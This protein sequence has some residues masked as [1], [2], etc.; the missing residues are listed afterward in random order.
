MMMLKRVYGELV[1]NNAIH[2]M[3][4]S[5]VLKIKILKTKFLNLF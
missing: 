1:K 2:T 4:T 5:M 3:D